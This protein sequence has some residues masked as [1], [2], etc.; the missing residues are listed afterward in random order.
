[1]VFKFNYEYL[2]VRCKLSRAA[3]RVLNL[4]LGLAFFGKSKF[5]VCDLWL[6][7]FD[8]F[9]L[10]PPLLKWLTEQKNPKSL[11]SLQYV[12]CNTT[13]FAGFFVLR[14]VLFW[15]VHETTFC[16][17]TLL[18]QAQVAMKIKTELNTG[19]NILHY[20]WRNDYVSE[21]NPFF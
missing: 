7:D 18:G 2:H 13:N 1:M 15:I 19:N 14:C 9:C 6:L 3:D 21:A 12:H 8:R 17:S 10:F 20:M 4:S 5:M 11:W 16:V